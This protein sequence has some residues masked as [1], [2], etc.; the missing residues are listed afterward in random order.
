MKI[1]YKD[2]PLATTVELD[3]GEKRE[4]RLKLKL[5]YLEERISSAHFD[6]D[7]AHREWKQKHLNQAVT[8]EDSV[9]AALKSLDTGFLLDGEER[10]GRTLDSYLDERLG[11]YVEALREEHE[12]DCTCIPC[13]CIKC[14]AES[15]VGVDTIAGL[16]KHPGSKLSGLFQTPKGGGPEPTIDEVLEKLRDYKPVKGPGWERYTEEDFQRNVPRW[17]A[18]A[19][20]AYDWLL[21]YKKSKLNL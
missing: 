12:G 21:E 17:T 18:E 4:L 13:S 2:N 8:I 19:K 1:T 6:L 14:H 7:P 16:G 20:H 3:E 9:T 5:E 10:N 15:L 11:Y